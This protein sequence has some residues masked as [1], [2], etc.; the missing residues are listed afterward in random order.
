MPYIHRH[1]FISTLA[2]EKTINAIHKNNTIAAIF[3][4]VAEIKH[5]VEPIASNKGQ[6]PQK[7]TF[8]EW[9]EAWSA[10]SYEA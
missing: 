6:P 1:F 5:M 8:L 10:S 2:K 3:G 7:I 9:F 4:T